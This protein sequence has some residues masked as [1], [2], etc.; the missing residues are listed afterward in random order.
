MSDLILDK[1]G[2]AVANLRQLTFDE[3]SNAFLGNI[4]FIDAP[5][6]L[7]E[8]LT[9]LETLVEDQT[10]SL[11]DGLQ[12]AID[13][14]DLTVRFNDNCRHR[15]RDLYVTKDGGFSFRIDSEY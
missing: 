3:A 1:N 15:I 9:R 6:G 5:A 7:Q 13:A 11:V 4:E 12:S 8:L 2:E 10:F 14:F